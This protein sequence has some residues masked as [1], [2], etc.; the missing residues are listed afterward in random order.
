MRAN[1]KL[2]EMKLLG[3]DS[4]IHRL[5]LY[6]VLRGLDLILGAVAKH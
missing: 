3:S 5:S 4:V 2:L 1:R 6:V